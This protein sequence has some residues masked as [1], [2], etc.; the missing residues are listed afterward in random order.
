MLAVAAAR[1]SGAFALDVC[2]ELPTPGVAALFGRSG[3]GKSM[4]VNTIAAP[5]ARS[6]ISASG[7]RSNTSNVP[8]ARNPSQERSPGLRV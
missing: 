3:S 5:L 2:F 7:V 1:K 4:V 6:T 8:S